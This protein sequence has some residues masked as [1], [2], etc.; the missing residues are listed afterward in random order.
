MSCTGRQCVR[1]DIEGKLTPVQG[2]EASNSEPMAILV[3]ICNSVFLC[4]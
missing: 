4:L 2:E 1:N 3:S